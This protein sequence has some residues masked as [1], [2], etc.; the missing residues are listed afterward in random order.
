MLLNLWEC[1]SP[2]SKGCGITAAK[3]R[4]GGW[5]ENDTLTTD[6]RQTGN[7]PEQVEREAIGIRTHHQQ[8]QYNNA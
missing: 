1:N 5:K 3:Q 8:Q 4:D 7:Y 2:T 6:S